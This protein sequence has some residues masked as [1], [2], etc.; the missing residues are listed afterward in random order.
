MGLK[1]SRSLEQ[2]GP[3]ALTFSIDMSNGCPQ[4]PNHELTRR[5]TIFLLTSAMLAATYGLHV[6]RS[7][8]L[9]FG[10]LKSSPSVDKKKPRPLCNL[11]L[12]LS[13][14]AS[15]PPTYQVTEPRKLEWIPNSTA[16]LLSKGSY[17]C[18]KKSS[19]KTEALLCP[20]SSCLCLTEGGA[21]KPTVAGSWAHMV[22]ALLVP[23]V[24]F[25]DTEGQEGIDCS[26]VPKKRWEIQVIQVL[27]L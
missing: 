6:D 26:K 23:D 18:N 24:L 1:V 16:Y 19:N 20:T 8:T 14:L 22:C 12:N 5:H 15:S 21:L 17:S 27:W 2:C 7:D 3:T 11:R 9:R 4:T 10:L 25:A 13:N